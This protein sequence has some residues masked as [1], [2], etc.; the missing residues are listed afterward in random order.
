MD[1]HAPLSF[2]Y[3]K[4]Y[5]DAFHSGQLSLCMETRLEEALQ[6]EPDV[7]GIS[8]Y[9]QDFLDA[10]AACRK[11]KEAGV[12]WVVL[13]GMHI[14]A[15]PEMLPDSAD[16][17]VIGEGEETFSELLKHISSGTGRTGEL[18]RIQG[19]VFREDNGRIQITPARS[20]LYDL[21][22]L[23]V[24]DRKF[25][26]QEPGQIPHLFTSRG[27]PYRCSFCSSAHLSPH[28]RL[29]GASRIREEIRLIRAEFPE[30]RS[31]FIWDN[32]FI[33]NRRRLA[34]LFQLLRE[35]PFF[36][37]LSLAVAVRAELVDEELCLLLK[38]LHVTHAGLGMESGTDKILK[39]LKAPN[40]SVARNQAALDQLH[41]HGIQSICSFI[42]GH[43]DETESDVLATYNFLLENYGQGKISGHDMNILTP[44]PKTPL[45][46]WARKHGYVT[47]DNFAWNRLRYAAVR[48]NN[49]NGDIRQWAEGRA[50]NQSIYL[51]GHHIP[52]E[53]MY[54]IISLCEG[55]IDSRDF[56][57][58]DSAGM[59]RG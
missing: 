37:D 9:S 39:M 41:R 50:R 28:F 26:Q 13:G 18:S 1:Y 43:F 33:A 5:L 45:W 35:E 22:R 2:G 8:C 54:E 24:P 31:L 52:L 23:P 4:S 32:L 21:D 20:V 10:I 30:T 25:I 16:V 47:E 12:P 34:E 36:Q 46:D 42:V 55:K 51:N 17:G 57:L 7:L 53:R 40:S 19:I 6:S 11:A 44:L 14:T 56:S 38:Q 3:L 59:A 49:L 29:H 48:S 58:V 15:Y 27:C